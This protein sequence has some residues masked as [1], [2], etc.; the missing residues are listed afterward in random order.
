MCSRCF[1]GFASIS[2]GADPG[3]T[4]KHDPGSKPATG[5]REQF[6]A[7]ALGARDPLDDGKAQAGTS[8]V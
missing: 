7:A 8:G 4:R 2:S 3:R 6:E 5:A 1:P